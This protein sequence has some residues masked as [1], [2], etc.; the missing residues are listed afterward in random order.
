MSPKFWIIT[1]IAIVMLSACTAADDSTSTSGSPSDVVQSAAQAYVDGFNNRDLTQFKTYF[2]TDTQGADPAGL[3]QTLD[4]AE[5]TM[6][7]AEDND[8][9]QLHDF[10][11]TTEET[12]QQNKLS[13]VHYTANVSIVRNQDLVVFSGN[14][15]QDVALTKVGDKWLISGGDAPQITSDQVVPTSEP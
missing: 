12:D 11:I 15:E 4:A 3:A 2:A 14:I 6:K 9:F 1:A 8:Q 10:Q 5:K 7:T 13:T